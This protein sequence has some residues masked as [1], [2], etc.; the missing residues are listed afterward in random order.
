MTNDQNSK[1]PA[2]LAEVLDIRILDFVLVGKPGLA[3]GCVTADL[4]ARPWLRIR[5]GEIRI[6]NF[7]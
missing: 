7:P 1:P 5:Y 2:S 6:S 3:F 4:K